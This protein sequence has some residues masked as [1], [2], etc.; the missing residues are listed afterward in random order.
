ME[1]SAEA[2]WAAFE[3]ETGEKVLSKTMGQIFD[4]PSDRGDWGLL[5]LSPSSFRFR[6]TPGQNWFASLF[7]ASSPPP[8]QTAADDLV[9]PLTSIKNLKLPPKKLLDMLFGSPFVIF[10]LE[11]ETFS[12]AVKTR[13]GV[14]PKSEFFISLKKSLPESVIS[15]K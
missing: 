9:I 2:F 15:T 10:T 8:P 5:V 1:K 7:K 3:T 6:K 4:S 11:H 13:F 12:G 14:D